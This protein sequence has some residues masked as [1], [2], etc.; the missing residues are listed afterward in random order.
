[1]RPIGLRGRISEQ[2][3]R[4]TLLLLSRGST[5][6]RRELEARLRA[7]GP[8]ALLDD[9]ELLERLVAVRTILVP[10]EP[11]FYYVA[12]RHTL[13]RAGLDDRALA[14]FLAGLLIEFG[15]RDRAYR[16]DRSDENVHR[17]LVDLLAELEASG[18]D[19]RFAVLL[20]LGN[21]ALWLAGLFP[22][23]IAARRLRHGG[24]DVS[25]YD[26]LG[27]RG[28]E[29][30]ADHPLAAPAGLS[31]VLHVAAQRFP[32]VRLAL[33]RLSDRVFF[34]AA[35]TPDRILRDLAG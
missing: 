3:V 5:R 4:L 15:Q 11:L 14:E 24:P 13:L 26:A 19:R 32:T 33:N 10:S 34:P 30:A 31:V 21:Y 25:Y 2:D 16:V 12:V 17:Y 18:P 7:E 20:H 23:H 35:Y 22:D 8:D 1:M 29:G 9:P 27:R 6:R 28:Y